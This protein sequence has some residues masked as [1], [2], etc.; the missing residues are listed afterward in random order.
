MKKDIYFNIK[1]TDALESFGMHHSLHINREG[2]AC[3]TACSAKHLE[4]IESS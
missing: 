4:A 2:V 1:N 3:A